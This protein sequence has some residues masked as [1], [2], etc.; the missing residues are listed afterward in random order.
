[1]KYVCEM[2]TEIRNSSLPVWN[3]RTFS[4]YVGDDYAAG[5]DLKAAAAGFGGHFQL[6]AT[7]LYRLP[8]PVNPSYRLGSKRNAQRNPIGQFLS[9]THTLGQHNDPAHLK[10]L[11][12]NPPLNDFPMSQ[13][14]RKW[15]RNYFKNVVI[16]IMTNDNSYQLRHWYESVKTERLLFRPMR[17]NGRFFFQPPLTG[18]FAP[19]PINIFPWMFYGFSFFN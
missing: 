12:K 3:R 15:L 10:T 13:Q 6:G 16:K 17:K 8:C 2:S 18:E 1:M 14:K 7:P 4:L 5:G 9:H 11:H 19:P